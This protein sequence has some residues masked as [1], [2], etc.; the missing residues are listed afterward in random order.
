M[1]GEILS[2]GSSL[3]GGL[4]GKK[5]S[6]KANKQN[7]QLQKDFAQQGIQW[8]VADAKAAG[9]HPLAALGASTHSFSPSVVG[10]TALP[11][12]MAN[13]GQDLGRAINSTRS[14]EQR[15]QAIG[16]DIA[17]A[18]LTGK[19]LENQGKFIE[20]Q[21]LASKLATSSQ[22][23]PAMA[24]GVNNTGMDGQNSSK[25]TRVDIG[26]YR[27]VAA[28][29]SDAQKFED[30]YGE[31]GAAGAGLVIGAADAAATGKAYLG[32]NPDVQRALGEARD[33]MNQYVTP[34]ANAGSNA[35]AKAYLQGIRDAAASR[36]EPRR[37]YGPPMPPALWRRY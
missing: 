15:V 11:T 20:N 35:M 5:S 17:R 14:Q 37:E 29:V 12:A 7:I 8:K 1:L 13:I 26:P 24:G 4:F 18:E 6:E 2:A 10:D 28:N 19:Q 34:N 21:L 3:L 22:V 23:G 16:T 36:R 32:R 33:V 31:V 27:S 25:F 9:I 30:R